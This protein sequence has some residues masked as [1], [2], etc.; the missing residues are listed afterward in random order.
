MY[1]LIDGDLYRRREGG[2]FL[3]C[4]SREE[5]QKLLTDIHEGT[6]SSHVASRALAGRAFRQG[7][8]WPT[9]LSDAGYL[10]KTCDACQFHAKN[11]NQPAQ[12]LQ[13]IPLSWPFAVWGLDIVGHFPRAVGGYRYLLVAID[14]FTK[15]VEVEPV[16]TITAQAAI[17][18]IRGIVCRFGVPNRIITDNG[19]Q[20]T[21][22][23]FKAYCSELG[24]KICFASV[25]HPR[26]NGQVEG[27]NAE[28][29]RGLNMKT[30]D[31]LKGSRKAGSRRS[32]RCC[33]HC[34][35]RQVERPA[36][37][38]SPWCTGLRLS[39]PRSS[40]TDLP[41]YAHMTKR[42][43]AP[44]GLTTSTSSRRFAVGRWCD[45]LVTSKGCAAIIAGESI[46]GSLRKEI[47]SYAGSKTRRG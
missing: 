37:H 2:V 33:G 13:T 6:C 3:R 1:R 7:F 20:F 25:A 8:Y 44:R 31:R 24:T 23:A 4:I 40:S 12:A 28:V 26:A 39:C 45:P 21:S 47:L 16:R 41:E 38:H 30:F 22:G 36:K 18:F 43:S 42:L 46:P 27:G 32:R 11:V 5:G 29:L 17:K 35:P 10:V 9:A 15:W 14:K 34:V 19:T